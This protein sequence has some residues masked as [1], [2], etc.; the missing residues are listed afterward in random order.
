MG[1]SLYFDHVQPRCQS[2][3]ERDSWPLQAWNSW[4]SGGTPDRDVLKARRSAVPGL[5]AVLL[6]LAAFGRRPQVGQGAPLQ[7]GWTELP[8]APYSPELHDPIVSWADGELTVAGTWNGSAWEGL[9]FPARRVPYQK[10]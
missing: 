1:D 9:A 8:P 10:N 4:S 7:P 5:A 2:W 3:F 6:L